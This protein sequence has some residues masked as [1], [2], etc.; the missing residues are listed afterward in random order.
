MRRVGLS[1][2]VAAA[3]AAPV[4]FAAYRFAVAYRVHA[5]FPQPR[6]P[7]FTPH[8]F[9][10]PFEETVV[11][12]PAGDLPAWFVPARDGARGPAVLLVHG[13]ESARDRTLPNARFLH[14]AGFH[15]LSFDVRGHGANPR[16]ELPI[17]VAEFGAD[18]LAA[19]QALQA[20][21]EVTQVAILGH[22][23]GAVGAIFAAARDDRVAA[24][25]ST[26]APAGPVMLTRQ[27]FRL[28]RLP[29]PDA[30][31]YPLAWLTTRV[32]VRPRGHAVASIN[33]SRALARYS[34]PV[35]LIHGSEDGVIPVSHLDRLQAA[36]G[37]DVETLVLPG[38]EHS[39]LHE[40]AEYRR[41][42]AGFLAR[43]LDGPLSPDE[44]AAIAAEVDCPRLPETDEA[45]AAVDTRPYG[46]RAIA[47]VILPA[48][49][50]RGWAATSST[51]PRR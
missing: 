47:Q 36:A 50:A 33:A 19:F 6:P 37:R 48:R 17:S 21:P 32:Y 39:W 20:R 15:C 26:S 10:L 24:L 44:A 1:A 22:S 5:G 34:G 12:S 8:D 16:E 3:A 41:V 28:A 35:L 40:H 42:V 38:A 18:A 27:T 9:G 30:L 25:V 23:L 51:A 49:L 7:I 45:F 13:W 11:R 14:A 31:A 43:S 29:M 2:G 4:A 46:L